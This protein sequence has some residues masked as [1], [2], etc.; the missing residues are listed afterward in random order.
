MQP[1]IPILAQSEN[2][3]RLFERLGISDETE[4]GKRI[5]NMMKVRVPH[6]KLTPSTGSDVV[7]RRR[8]PL[9][10]EPESAKIHIRCFLNISMIPLSGHLMP[11]PR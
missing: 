10:A 9:Q 6:T 4:E 5:Y 7:D 3:S 2:K 1:Q 11:I 8:M